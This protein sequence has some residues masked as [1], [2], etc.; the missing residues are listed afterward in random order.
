MT[1]DTTFSS[2]FTPATPYADSLLGGGTGLD[3]F[4]GV[5]NQW[6]PIV[7]KTANT[8]SLITYI[9]HNGTALIDEF[10]LYLQQYGTSTGFSYG[11][12]DTAFNDITNLLALG[13][14]SGSSK[15]NADGLSGG[16]WAEFDADVS[17]ANFFD[18]ASRPTLVKV[19][20][21][22]G[23]GVSLATAY[24]LPADALIYDSGGGTETIA[25]AP[26]AGQIGESTNSTLG[27]RAKIYWR[28]YFPDSF[29]VGGTLQFE[30]VATYAFTA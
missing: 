11:G 27:D 4:V 22:G 15:N 8:G 1:V 25:T 26:V 19:F 16:I 17:A 9:S 20:G 12:T 10:K 14:A 5:N 2:T 13:S 3:F 6:T 7:D 30:I 24:D 29:G 21:A 28:G 23:L 18:R